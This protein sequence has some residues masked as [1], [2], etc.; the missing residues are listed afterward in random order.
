[1]YWSTLTS[2]GTSLCKSVNQR[3]FIFIDPLLLLYSIAIFLFE[4][5]T[6]LASLVDEKAKLWVRGRDSWKLIDAPENGKTVWI[7]CSSVGE[8]E[9][10]RPLI[11]SMKDEYFI[12][13]TYFSPSGFQSEKAKEVADE[14][15]Y[16]PTDHSSLAR[17]FLDKLQ[18]SAILFVKY[19]F[20]YNFM[21]EIHDRKIPFALISAYFPENYSLFRCPGNLLGHRLRQFDKI[22]VQD[23]ESQ[24]RLKRHL[25]IDVAEV[26]GDTR[27]DRVVQNRA[28][29][30]E[31]S[32]VKEFVGDMPVLVIGSNWP[33]DDEI[34]IPFLERRKDL[35]VIAAPHELGNKQWKK[36][37]DTFGPDIIDYDQLEGGE[38]GGRV[39]FVNRI[40]L[41][42]SLY[43]YA[44]VAYVGGGFGS[45]V[46]NTLEAAVW[47][48]PVLC[49]PKNDRFLEIQQL[50][51]REVI[52]EIMDEAELSRT[53]DLLLDSA[54]IREKVGL[55]AQKYFGENAGA[56]SQILDWLNSKA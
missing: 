18:P 11:E 24:D 51:S 3:T 17:A 20:W 28:A 21:E 52:Y 5:G 39:L 7:H 32:A 13:L 29:R 38:I 37:K 22:F 31:L 35:K 50:K 12:L 15:C 30:L 8:F 43:Q 56:T 47:S 23:L 34:L 6:R 14:V 33:S 55:E 53:L 10:A 27:V 40:G 42:S 4:V 48:I 26:S 19:E 2:G 49:G 1:M 41:L 36:W 44:T 25:G 45:A 16:L 9:Q 46:H 54:A